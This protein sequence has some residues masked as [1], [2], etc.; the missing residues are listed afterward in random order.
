VLAAVLQAAP[1]AVV[2][3]DGEG[4]IQLWSAAAE[5]VF[6]WTAT[7]VAARPLSVVLGA[8][9]AALIEG[10]RGSE[11]ASFQSLAA[12]HKQGALLR[13]TVSCVATRGPGGPAGVVAVFH[14]PGAAARDID[15]RFVEAQR[16]EV[17]DRV[18]GAIAHDLRN[19]FAAIKGFAIVAG[20]GFAAGHQ[21]RSDMEQI[22]KAVERGGAL[23]QKL[24][25][26]SRNPGL[27]PR[28]VDLNQVL[29]ALDA[30]IR[31]LVG[32]RL[33]LVVRQTP[34]LGLVKADAA[35][36]EQVIVNLVLNA[37][38]SMPTGGRLVLE[39]SNADLDRR[40]AEAEG[41][42]P[43]RYARLTVTD[44]GRGLAPGTRARLPG[45][46]PAPA[47]RDDRGPGLG[48]PATWS[49]VRQMGGQIVAR[50]EP[51]K[52]TTFTIDLPVAQE[53]RADRGLAA[54]DRPQGGPRVR[55]E[56]EA[57]ILIVEDDD[58]VRTLTIRV[59]R[60]R[61]Y[62]VLEA[63]NPAEAAQRAAEEAGPIHLLLSDVGLPQKSGPELARTL[64]GDRPEMKVLFMSGYGRTALAERGVVPGP[65]LLEKP[66]SPEAL[67]DRIRTVLDA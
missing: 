18:A 36:L 21:V 31:R 49:I 42:P 34:G 45:L 57:T 19:V 55:E 17:V 7:E 3:L 47:A 51:G 43:G 40:A 61:G 64:A 44:N 67:L 2:V 13:V 35:Q 27:E 32:A 16:L 58:L 30:T 60:R 37:R 39:T 46:E 12:A 28:V 41:V 24:L 5:R 62:R 25:A 15:Q 50:T 20:E 48:L 11:R 26:F 63:S 9:A 8:E 29:Q 23:T 38:D 22:L 66:F 10:A 33:E 1:S 53:Q 65:G 6:G 14:D 4:R 56:P 54:P 52:G 59:L